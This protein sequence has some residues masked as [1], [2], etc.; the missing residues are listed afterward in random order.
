MDPINVI[1]LFLITMITYTH[2]KSIQ[3]VQKV[4]LGFLA[5]S[6]SSQK[7]EITAVIFTENLRNCLNRQCRVEN[8]RR[9][10]F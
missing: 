7:T 10:T 3:V 2:D 9:E 6:A 1:Y 4:F 8:A 5:V